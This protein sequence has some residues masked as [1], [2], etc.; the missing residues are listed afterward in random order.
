MLYEVTYVDG[1]VEQLHGNTIA[2]AKHQALDL[3][4]MPVAKVVALGDED[5]ADEEEVDDEPDD[6][7]DEEEDLEPAFNGGDEDT[8]DQDD[9]A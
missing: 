4:D 2:D 9:E 3:Y 1:S 8:E 7:D 6:C 5:D